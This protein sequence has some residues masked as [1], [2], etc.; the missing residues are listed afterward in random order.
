[1]KLPSVP[2]ALLL[3]S[4]LFTGAP[5]ASAY[6]SPSAV[7]LGTAA[8]FGV[9]A[10]TAITNNG[11][12]VVTGGDVGSGPTGFAVSGFPPGTVVPPG[13]LYESANA[14]TAQANT[15]LGIAYSD[16]ASRTPDQTFPNGDGQLNGLVLSPGV[17]R[18]GSATTAQLSAG[19]LTLDANNDPDAV[20]IFQIPSTTFITAASTQILLSNLAQACNVYWQVGTSVTL[21]AASTIQGTIIADTSITIGNGVIVNGRL[22]AGAVTP[23]G[24]V[25]LDT[26]T[27]TVPTCASAGGGGGGGGSG[28]A[29]DPPLISL[30]KVPT[31]LALPSGS[32]SVTYSY[33]VRNIGNFPMI[34]VRVTDDKCANINFLSG[35]TNEDSILDL[36]ETWM[37]ECTSSI[38]ETTTNIAKASGYANGL[39]TLD[40]AI[41]TVIVGAAP[42]VVPPLIHVEKRPDQFFL[43]FGGEPITYTYTITNPGTASL[44]NVR[45]SDDKC[46]AISG[47]SGDRNNDGL[48]NSNEEWTYTCRMNITDTTTNTVTVRGTA[49]GLTAVDY[50][51]ATVVVNDSSSSHSAAPTS[52]S[53]PNTGTG[54]GTENYLWNIISLGAIV[55]AVF[56]VII[57]QKKTR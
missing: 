42:D 25:T 39:Q 55:S 56:F 23:S 38:T 11:S 15:D 29:T 28:R 43:A 40:T 8:N 54:F 48:L 34:R 57:L 30:E 13:T 14:A 5:S 2:L 6:V 33:E 35:D 22:L 47:R 44:R 17:Y 10:N 12:T 18:V 16:L 26:D 24:A 41:A 27:I 21:G 9:L 49:N 31:P 19:I 50:A 53:F 52:P 36:T 7:T 51:Y 37:Y 20:W 32:G 3:L 1:M 46:A 45:I 4:A